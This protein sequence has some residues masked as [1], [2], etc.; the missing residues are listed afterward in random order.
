MIHTQ[1]CSS[2]D[3][4]TIL[5]NL[6]E[7]DQRGNFELVENAET[8]TMA[9]QRASNE[10][11]LVWPKPAEAEPGWYRIKFHASGKFQ[12][13]ADNLAEQEPFIIRIADPGKEDAEVQHSFAFKSDKPKTVSVN[14]LPQP[15][16]NPTQVQVWQS[17]QPLR[18]N[19]NSS[20]ELAF[21]RQCAA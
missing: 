21:R 19:E 18:L 17:S 4:E 6:N 11:I 20:I 14:D 13:I 7:A 2:S 10:S 12:V 1:G 15:L 5:L 16:L 3:Q 9:I 8:G